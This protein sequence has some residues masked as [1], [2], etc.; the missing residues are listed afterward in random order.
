MSNTLNFEIQELRSKRDRTTNEVINRRQILITKNKG[1][2]S[3]NHA[4]EEIRK[5]QISLRQ[6]N[7]TNG[8]MRVTFVSNNN[9]VVFSSNEIN[10]RL[11]DMYQQLLIESGF[12]REDVIFSQ[13]TIQHIKDVIINISFN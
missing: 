11:F 12:T 10:G 13:P 7:L 8:H 1:F 4:Q 3:A 9:H 6:A 5:I 2:F